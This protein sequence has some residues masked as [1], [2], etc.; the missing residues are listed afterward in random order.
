MPLHQ[1]FFVVGTAEPD[2]KDAPAVTTTVKLNRNP[3]RPIPAPV[4]RQF[5]G[6]SDGL[7]RVS[8][9]RPSV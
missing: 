1:Q 8:V 2:R 3:R 4:P 7:L 5:L 6:A 9:L